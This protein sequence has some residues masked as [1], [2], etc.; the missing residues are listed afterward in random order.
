VAAMANGEMLSIIFFAI[1][2]G[3]SILMAGKKNRIAG[4]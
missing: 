3:V 4:R 2:T 1:L